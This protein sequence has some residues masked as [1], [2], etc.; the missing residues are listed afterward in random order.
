MPV[1]KPWSAIPI[2]DC[3]EPLRPLPPAFDRVEPHPY[4]RLGAPYAQSSPHQLRESVL[5]R[6]L[7]VQ[8][9]LSKRHPGW[10]LRIFDAYRP[11]AVQQFMVEH[12]FA[13]LLKA[14][15]LTPD[16]L[17][18]A[19]RTELWQTV[20]RY[21]ALPSEDP[22]T[23][24]AHSTG[25]AVDLT[26]ID[27]QGQPLAMGTPIDEFSAAAHPDYFAG[28]TTPQEQRFHRHRQFLNEL[29]QA[30]DFAQHPNEWWHFS[31]G[32]QLWAQR[33]RQRGQPAAVAR[34]GRADLV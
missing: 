6:L 17:D 27:D 22:A 4:L 18:E 8:H 33:A 24:P 26:L 31:Y 1:A 30:Q 11:N 10:R 21:W 5:N 13:T 28:A 14:R 15:Q 12:T 2:I 29:M 9:G 34:Y 23:P 3:G 7:R 25:A 20:F 16:S 32:D 19:T